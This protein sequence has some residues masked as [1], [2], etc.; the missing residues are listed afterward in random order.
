[1][2]LDLEV[3]GDHQTWELTEAERS[4]PLTSILRQRGIPLN[5]RCGERGLC[6]ACEVEVDGVTVQGCQCRVDRPLRVHVPDRARF[7]YRPQI[8]SGY[9]IEVPYAHAPLFEAPGLGVAVDIGTTTVALSLVDL[10]LGE[11]IATETG[12]NRQM[13]HGDDVLTR[14][15]RCLMEPEM[16]H[17]MY[18]ALWR[19]T[20]D[21]LLS[22][23]LDAAGRGVGEV[24]GTV[25]AGNTT[26]LHLAFDVNPSSLGVAPF[27][28]VFLGHE[29]RDLGWPR[30]GCPVHALP[31][32]AAYVGADITAGMLAGGF[33][34]DEGPSLFVDVG[35]NGEIVL[36]TGDG[37][38]LGSATAAGPAFEGCGLSAGMRAGDGAIAHLRWS[39]ETGL[40]V[41]TIGPSGTRAIGMCG[42]A[43]VDVLAVGRA[44]GKLTPSGRLVPGDDVE[45]AEYGNRW[46][47][48]KGLGKRPIGVD[49]ADLA[50]LLQA[51]AA[52][53]AGITVLLNRAG[54]RPEDLKSLV[55]AGGFGMHLDQENAIA[56]GLLPGFRSEQIR[57]VGNS[58]L[59]GATLSVLDRSFLDELPRVAESIEIVELNLDPDF[60]DTYIDCLALD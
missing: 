58:S 15:N 49:D 13:E 16:T 22:A 31:S 19:D 34:Y 53:A 30:P 29:V 45:P 50:R 54:L 37:T 11:V 55:L 6:Q 56:C 41:E 39:S 42:S 48:A 12:F 17:A 1:M 3:G 35:T 36:N 32:A 47:L 2:R 27:D 14:I 40:E 18:E 38:R 4:V 5:T 24:K 51:K 28:A 20:L 26:M 52:I 46:V 57:L 59:A 23:A 25:L 10:A 60:E 21:P 9:R 7:A 33:A 44:A 43:Y 8:Q